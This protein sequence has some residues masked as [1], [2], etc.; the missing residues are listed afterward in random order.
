MAWQY[1]PNIS[2]VE[3]AVGYLGIATIKGRFTNVK[4]TLNLEDA[5]PTEW[6]VDA[7]IESASLFSGHN[8]MDD[9]VR[10]ADFLDVAQYPTIAFKGKRVEKANDGYRLV[11]DL[12]L[13]G[14][15]RE[16]AFEGSYGGQAT[17]A[18]GKTKRGFSGRTLLRRGD[19]G[20]PSGKSGE[21]FV[22]SD[23]IR[24]SLEVVANLVD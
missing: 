17:D 19:F 16:V 6:S 23:E 24:V 11:G 8:A 3:W 18:R 14:V 15:T 2:K 22:A 21:T 7:E 9:H 20:I 1:D 10:S 5:D 12:T 4:A 13:R